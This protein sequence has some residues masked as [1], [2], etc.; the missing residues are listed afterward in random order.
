MRF[1]CAIIA[2]LCISAASAEETAFLPYRVDVPS[3]DFPVTLG[4]EYAKLLSTGALIAGL[5][6]HSPRELEA[7]LVRSGIDP[8]GTVSG[9]E[10]AS[11]GKSRLIDHFIIGTLYKKASGYVSE[12][13]L[14]SVKKGSV[15][16]RARVSAAD[17]V[18]LGERELAALFPGKA[19]FPGRLPVQKNDIAIVFDCSYAVASEWRSV[20]KGIAELAA[21][22]TGNWNDDARVSLVPFSSFYGFAHAAHALKNAFSLMRAMENVAPKGS[23]TE[24]AFEQA[25]ADSVRNIRWRSDA[26]KRVVLI[27]NTPLSRNNRLQNTAQSARRK[28]IRVH[29]VALGG[30]YGEGR[31]CLAELSAIAGGRHFDVAY[32]KKIFDARG[33]EINLYLEAGRLFTSDGYEGRWKDGLFI[34]RQGGPQ[35]ARPKKFFKEIFFD[36]KKSTP[37]PAKMGRLYEEYSKTPIVRED[38]LVNNMSNLASVIVEKTSVPGQRESKSLGRVLVYQDSYSIWVEVVRPEDLDFFRKKVKS[39]E[40]FLLGVSIEEKREEPFGI[41]FNPGRYITNVPS[42]YL[43]DLLKVRLENVV[44]EKG[45]YSSHGFF[46]PPIWFV[47]LKAERVKFH[48]GSDVR[49]E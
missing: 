10:L 21:H 34:T 19:R 7:D 38:E 3:K 5:E 14:F 30:I 47:E 45:H 1:F 11:L 13:V 44:K 29:T 32:H 23:G 28:G 4:A 42:E 27:S 41:R 39:K 6:V 37:V 9:E 20:K 33:E 31:N 48:K 40:V 8:Q 12:S 24:K 17:L 15:I 35:S 36:D 2:V 26:V 49:D 16:S 18:E 43:P 25:F 22:M 46:N